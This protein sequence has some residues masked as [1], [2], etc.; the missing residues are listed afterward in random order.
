MQSCGP[1][2]IEFENTPL[3]TG[4]KNEMENILYSSFA[5]HLHK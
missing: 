4:E 1:P 2:G 5:L 3:V